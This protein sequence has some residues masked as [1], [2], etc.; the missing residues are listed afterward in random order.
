MDADLDRIISYH[1]D[2]AEIRR[3]NRAARPTLF[4]SRGCLVMMLRRRA[5]Q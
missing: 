2:L 4:Q 1:W 5:A 3:M